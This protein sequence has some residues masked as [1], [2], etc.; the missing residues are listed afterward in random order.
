M[1]SRILLTIIAALVIGVIQFV[2]GLTANVGVILVCGAIMGLLSYGLWE[3]RRTP[4]DSSLDLYLPLCAA[5]IGITG[6]VLLS[7][8]MQSPNVSPTISPADSGFIDVW[9]I[10]LGLVFAGGVVVWRLRNRA[11]RCHV[12]RRPLARNLLAP[13]LLGITFQD[14]PRCANSVC[15]NCWN[16]DSFRCVVCERT[17]TPLLSIEEDEWWS[18]RLGARQSVGRCVRCQR[19]AKERDL[20][21]C[22]NCPRTMCVH[23]WDMENGRC[24]GCDWVIRGLPQSLMSCHAS[25]AQVEEE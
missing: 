6:G 21:K 22:G 4:D 1:G 9:A 2:V 25:Q 14:C 16:A 23:C 8:E 7:R 24:I 15:L 12:C 10:P 20:R 19:N 18:E 5:V 13:K 11:A 3:M 17:R